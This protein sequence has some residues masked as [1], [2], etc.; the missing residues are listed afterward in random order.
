MTA[1]K[2]EPMTAETDVDKGD[3]SGV[4][5]IARSIK[6]L[7]ALSTHP[8]GMSLAAIAAH[9]GLPRSTVQRI[10]GALDAEHLVESVG[11]GGGVRLGPALGQMLYQTQTDIIMV[12]RQHLEKLS[13]TF[14]ETV[15]L[16]RLAGMNTSILD[17]VIGDQILRVVIPIGVTVPLHLTADGKALLA[18]MSREEVNEWLGGDMPQQTRTSKTILQLHDELDE[19][20]KTGVAFDREEIDEGICAISVALETY[21]GAYAICIIV[22]THR[23]RK[24]AEL[25]KAALLD[26]KTV[27]ER[28]IG[29]AAT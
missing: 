22:P 25:F 12:A 6:I 9:V 27:L 14:G 18:L 15:I 3:R 17:Q 10:I 23:M 16:S 8:E 19:V 28:Q 7:R 4:Q 24:N 13:Q 20:R 1:D 5:V 2:D 11:P 21:M 29:I 26:T